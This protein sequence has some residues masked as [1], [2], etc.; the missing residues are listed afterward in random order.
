MSENAKPATIVRE[1]V[2]ASLLI[3]TKKEREARFV[4]FH[5]LEFAIFKGP[6]AEQSANLHKKEKGGRGEVCKLGRFEKLPVPVIVSLWEQG[7]N[8]GATL[9]KL[10]GKLGYTL[11]DPAKMRRTAHKAYATYNAFAK[12]IGK[13]EKNPPV[14]ADG[15]AV[16][17]LAAMFS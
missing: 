3:D 8:D 12:K 2:D 17:D 11:Y 9:G 5:G 10:A 6:L 14:I 13:P 4:W 15:V 16:A 7:A 1:S